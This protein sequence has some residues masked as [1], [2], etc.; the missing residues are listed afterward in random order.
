GMPQLSLVRPASIALHNLAASLPRASA[1]VEIRTEIESAIDAV[2]ELLAEPAFGYSPEELR[3]AVE[4]KLRQR[5]VLLC[6][7]CAGGER[8]IDIVTIPVRPFLADRGRRADERPLAMLVCDECGK[9]H[10]HDLAA[11]RVM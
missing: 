1:V 2:D 6:P 11:L 10:W 5:N 7:V 9:V 3:A 8:T 4:Q